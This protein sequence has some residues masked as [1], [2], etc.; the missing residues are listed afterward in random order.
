MMDSMIYSK[1]FFDLQFTFAEK[2]RDLSGM[3]LESVLLDYT[4]FYVRFGLGRKFEPEHQTWQ[5]YLAGLRDAEDVREWTYRFYLKDPEATTAPHLAATFGCF[6]YALGNADHIRLHFRNAE[7]EDVS[8]LSRARI[9]QR[10]AELR[11]LFAHV[12]ETAGESIRVAG[13]S[14]LYNLDAYRRLF[15]PMYGLSARIV[16]GRFRSMPLWGQFVDYRGRVRESVARRFLQSLAQHSSL[17]DLDD[18]FPLQALTVEAAVENF[19]D[20]YD[21]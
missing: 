17:A 20:F 2:V 4:N 19:Y 1:E 9:E 10:R 18:C 3:P 8:P 11:A 13:V 14:W 16:R 7:T 5:T 21:V 12:K 6:S 15:P